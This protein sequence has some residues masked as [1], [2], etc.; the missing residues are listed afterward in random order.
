MTGKDGVSTRMEREKGRPVA[1]KG[2]APRKQRTRQHVIAAQSVNH[3]ERFIIDEGHTTERMV[4]DYGYDLTMRTYGEEGYAEE[5]SVYLQLKAAET[6]TGSGHEFV[7]DIDRR[8]Y[9]LWTAELMPVILVLFDASLRRVLGLRPT[10]LRRGRVAQ[11]RKSHPDG[12]CSCT[13]ATGRQPC[14]GPKWRSYKQ[15]VLE[16][17]EG[18]IDHA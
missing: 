6:L 16:Q 1:R 3:V 11:A 10:L 4:G 8:D 7:F 12:S 15:R 2:S 9:A 14:G 18:R 13:E 5:G 17:T